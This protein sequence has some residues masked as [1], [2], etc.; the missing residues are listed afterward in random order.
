MEFA[1]IVEVLAGDKTIV[2][3]RYKRGRAFYFDKREMVIDMI[4]YT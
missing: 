4:W 2:L 1:R 3:M